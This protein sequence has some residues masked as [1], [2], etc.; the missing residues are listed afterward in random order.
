[1]PVTITYHVVV[2]VQFSDHLS[3]Q[4]VKDHHCARLAS[5]VY[6]P[7]AC[8]TVNCDAVIAMCSPVV[9]WGEK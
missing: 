3:C 4:D 7:L 8:E 2:E 5:G 6:I 9:N 1:M